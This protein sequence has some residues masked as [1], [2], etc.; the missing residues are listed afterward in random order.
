M[1]GAERAAVA[2]VPGT[3]AASFESAFCDRHTCWSTRAGEGLYRDPT[4]LS[5]AGALLLTDRFT[6]LIAAYARGG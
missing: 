4:H 6:R 1:V 3:S 5:V 2:A